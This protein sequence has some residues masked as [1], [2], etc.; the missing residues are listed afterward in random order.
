MENVQ[1]LQ[2]QAQEYSVPNTPTTTVSTKTTTSN[3]EPLK[4]T[5]PNTPMTSRGNISQDTQQVV[6]KE[7]LIHAFRLNRKKQLT[8]ERINKYNG[9]LMEELKTPRVKASN[10]ALMVINYTEQTPD[11][12]IPDI[13]GQA[14]QNRFKQ[15]AQG[16]KS[17]Q[18]L[19]KNGGGGQNGQANNVGAG[20][21]GD[22]CCVIM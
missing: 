16:N 18:L 15:A 17:L 4:L 21:G 10:C 2:A 3:T 7:K 6:M 11:P 12:L 5:A 9:K 20:D 19:N 13:W 8:L 14:E 22:G 1:Y